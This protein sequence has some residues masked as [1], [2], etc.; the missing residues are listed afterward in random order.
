[1]QRVRRIAPWVAGCLL[2]PV[3]KAQEP[4]R[5]PPEEIVRILEAPPLPWVSV[6][7]A[8]N[9]VLFLERESLPPISAMAQPM[10]RLAGQR[11]NP[12]TNG[13]FGPRYLIGMRAKGT[14]GSEIGEV[15]VPAE[16]GLGFP[17]WSADGQ[18]A[19]YSVTRDA[20]GNTEKSA[21]VAWGVFDATRGNF[22]VITDY[23]ANPLGPGPHWMPGGS[24]FVATFLV[25]DR[26]EAPA[27]SAIP[28]G[29]IVQ[30]NLGGKPAPVRTYQDLLQDSHDELLFEHHFT[31]QI[32]LVDAASGERREIAPAGLY[33]E[34]KPSPDG[35]YLLV[36]RIQRPFSFLVP[37]YRFPMSVEVWDL[38][39]NVVATIAQ[40]PLAERVPIQGVITGP[41][42]HQWRATQ[43]TAEIVWVEA[44]DG[45]DPRT[46]ASERDRVM[47]LSS[48]FNGEP[49]EVLRLEDRY[50]QGRWLAGTSQVLIKEY[51]RD[52]RWSRSWL[53]DVDQPDQPG[54]LVFDHSVQDAYGDPGSPMTTTNPGGHT[55]LRVVDGHL[56]LEGRGASPEGDR[57]FLD[58]LSLDSLEARRLWR[59]AGEEYES[60]VDFLAASPGE[61]VT[62]LT[63]RETP[64]QP[65]NYYVRNVPWTDGE[66]SRSA[67]TD[68]A[69]PAPELLDINKELITY[70]REDGVDL[71][72]TLYLPP[73]HQEGDVHPLL[74]WAYPR[75]FNDPAMAGQVRGSPWKFTL[76][77]GSSHLF[78]LTQGYAILDGA[79]MPVVG[80]D[81]ETVND[82]FLDQI[83]ASAAA[84]IQEA[85]RRGVADG[86]RVGVGGHS[87]GAFMTANLL[88]HCDLFRAGVA[89]SGAYNRSL[90]PFGFQAE[91]RTFWEAPETYF[92]L[93]PFMHA[94]KINEPM[95]MI[96][97]TEDNNSGTFPIQSERMYHAIK[98]H[99]GITRL[100]MLPEESHGYRARESVM[101]TLAEMVD[102]FD[103]WVKAP[104]SE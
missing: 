91:R 55:V 24:S 86:E 62:V 8:G 84:A 11:V 99:G 89:R 85:V 54:R 42:N 80:D 32:A 98:G 74:V 79:T 97:G 15:S 60:S 88:A 26:G 45:G 9:V 48:P 56:L 76:F 13:R 46:E 22:S 73:D 34:A 51:D 2:V 69:H 92:R 57:P 39:G 67:I 16:T 1:M 94:H 4:Y 27:R 38:E 81:P 37:W 7:P 30:E 70:P 71:S 64:T 87:Y 101:H 102:W 78:L 28:T 61:S 90:T 29:P 96:H 25:K 65:P 23:Q 14:D 40:L 19:V 82:T 100:V 63:K 43:G 52:E 93:S 44:L 6:S 66:S 95:L 50:R 35:R 77:G 58:L 72:A 17:S 41:R 31:S 83:V 3:A 10:L 21:G 20:T 33:V 49:R 103:R 68:F 5:Q 104:A 59:N 18:R 12:A 36:E 75:E 47:L 53:V